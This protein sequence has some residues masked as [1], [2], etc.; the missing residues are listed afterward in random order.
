MF[1]RTA[2]TPDT[3]HLTHFSLLATDQTDC[4][5]ARSCLPCIHKAWSTFVFQILPMHFFLPQLTLSLPETMGWNIA[6]LSWSHQ[7]AMFPLSWP[8]GPASLSWFQ[9]P[10]VLFQVPISLLTIMMSPWS[11]IGMSLRQLQLLSVESH[12][13]V[14][15]GHVPSWPKKSS[16]S[17][18]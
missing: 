11:T 2:F 7:M 4:D 6:H 1:G 10:S 15:T 13:P 8:R 3:S 16:S 14:G 5:W 17:Y 9:C 18:F 12:A